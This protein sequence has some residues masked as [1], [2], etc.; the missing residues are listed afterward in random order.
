MCW[1]LPPPAG[2]VGAAEASLSIPGCVEES[3]DWDHGAED[4]WKIAGEA[5]EVGGEY[6]RAVAHGQQLPLRQ[7]NEVPEKSRAQ[8]CRSFFVQMLAGRYCL[9]ERGLE[10]SQI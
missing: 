1:K 4:G 6:G 5:L 2:L 8:N 3:R 9:Q 10:H 7:M